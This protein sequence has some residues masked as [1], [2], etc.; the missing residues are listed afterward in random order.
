M[1]A[2]GNEVTVMAGGE[3]SSFISKI[4]VAAGIGVIFGLPPALIDEAGG[5]SVGK[6]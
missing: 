3:V 5:Q 1:N 2:S 4:V 6:G